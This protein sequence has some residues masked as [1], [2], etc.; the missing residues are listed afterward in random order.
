L[1]PYFVLALTAPIAAALILAPLPAY[2]QAA[3]STCS[4][5]APGTKNCDDV[6]TGGIGYT[7]GVD[8]VN[9]SNTPAGDPS[10]VNVNSGTVG[11]LLT[12]I[13]GDGSSAV[14]DAALTT[15]VH[16]NNTPGDTNDDF[17]ALTNAGGSF[18]LDDNGN[19]IHVVDVDVG[20]GVT[21]QQL[22]DAGGN[23]L[24]LEDLDTYL[25]TLSS[26]GAGVPVGAVTVV[27]SANFQS[28]NA[29]G[30][31]ATA[32]GGNGGKGGTV[33]IL[34]IGEVG[35]KG[36][37]GRSGGSVAVTND[38]TITATG[39][40]A[41]GIVAT[42]RGGNGGEG[43]GLG[44]LVSKAGSGGN[45]GAGGDVAVE[46]QAGSDITTTGDGGHGVL[47][48]SF[49]GDGGKG[50]STGG[51]VALGSKGGNGGVGGNVTVDNAGSI[52]TSGEAA[53]GIYARSYGAGAGSGSSVGGIYAA[54]G[55]GGGDNADGGTVDVSNSGTITT[56]GIGS[57]GVYLQSI[58]GGGGD[59]GNAG[60]L[61]TVGGK[62]GSGGDG[63]AVTYTQTDTGSVTTTKDNATAILA[64]S[65]GGGG[66]N[67]G[68]A[69]SISPVAV[70]IGGDAGPGGDG[71]TVTLNVAGTVTTSGKDANGIQA[72]SIGGGGGTGGLAVAGSI[73]PGPA[74][75][76]ALGG[77]GGDGGDAKAVEVISTAAITTGDDR[78]NGIFAQSVGGGG[79][80]G[81]LAISAAVG[82]G[83]FSAA[84]ALGGSG[85]PGGS[86]GKVTVDQTGAIVTGGD[87][88]VGINAQSIGGGGGN[89]GGSVAVAASGAYSLGFSMGG[90]AG[91]GGTAGAVDV[92]LNGSIAT[93]GNLSHG[94]FA[95]S[96]GGGGGNGGYSVAATAG[97]MSGSLALGGE[98]AGGATGGTVNVT[99]S[100]GDGDAITTQGE[101]AVGIFAQSVGGGGGNGGIAGS[102]ALGGGGIGVSLGGSGGGGSVGGTVDVHNEISIGTEGDKA[103]GILAQSVGGGGG[104][105]GFALSGAGGVVGIGAAIGGS[106]GA[107]S[108]G[109]TVDVYSSGDI[110]TLGK[111]AYGIQAQSVGGG[112]GNGGFAVSGAL[113]VSVQGIPGASAAIAI[114][115]TGGEA[116]NGDSVDVTNEGS[117]ETSGEGSHAIFAQSVG[118]G[119]GAG[120]FAGSLAATV[121]NG[122]AF[123]LSLGGDGGGGGDGGAVE[124]T[125]TGDMIIT[126]EAGA[127]GIHAQ[128]IGG[129]GGDGGFAFSGAI[130]LGESSSL[131]LSFG[132]DGEAGG[133]GSTVQ[134]TNES[135][136]TTSGDQAHGILAQSVGGGGGSGA[137]SVGGSAS[138]KGN[139]IALSFGGDGG[140]GGKGDHVTVS[141]LGDITT[142]GDGSYGILAQSIGGGGGAGGFSGALSLSGQ[143]DAAIAASFGGSAAN[144]STAGDVSVTHKLGTISTSGDNATGVFAQSVGGSGGT[145]GFSLSAAGS[146]D[147]T[148]QSLSVGGKGGE[149]QDSGIVVVGGTVDRATGDVTQDS[150]TGTIV[151]TGAMS[152]GIQAQSIGGGGGNGGFSVGLSFSMKDDAKANS[153][154]GEGEGGGDANRVEVYNE[155]TIVTGGLSGEG[156]GSHGIFAQSVGGGGGSGGFSA[157]GA[158][159]MEGE[160]A[161]SSVGGKG[162]RAGDGE[163]VI[164]GSA[165]TIIT[166]AVNSHG[167]L[168]QSIGGGGG[169]GAFSLAAGATAGDDA[170]SESVGGSGGSGGTGGDVV[171]DVLADI[172]TLGDLSY[173]VLAQSVGGGGGSGGFSISGSASLE[174]ESSNKSVGGS[175]SGGGDG[176]NVTV[177]IGAEGPPLTAP[178][179][180]TY[181][182]GAIGVLAQSIGG[183]G[184]NGGFSGGLSLATS[185][186]AENSV[187]SKKGANGGLAGNG[188]EVSV[189]NWGNVLTEGNNAAGIL[190]QSVGGGGGNGGFTI[191][192]SLDSKGGANNSIGGAAAG[193]GDGGLVEVD[194]N[195]TIVTSGNF[196]HGIIAQSIGG[197]GGNGGFSVSGSMS[198]GDNGA[199]SKIGGGAGGGGGDGGDVVVNNSG[200]ILVE[201]ENSFGVFA[202]SVGG[203]GGAGGFAGGLALGGK[204][205]NS[206][207]GE[208]G[209]GGDGGDVTV[210]ST[211]SIVTTQANSSA[212][213][214]QS[215]AGGGGWGGFSIALGTS[216]TAST[217]LKQGLGALSTLYAGTTN[218]TRGTVTVNISGGDTQT[219]GSLSYGLLAQSVGGGGGAVGTVAAGTFAIA[220]GDIEI[221]VGS[222]GSVDGD[223]LKQESNYANNTTTDGLGAIGLISQSIGGGGG[224]SGTVIEDTLALSGTETFDVQV[225][226]YSGGAGL[227]GSGSGGGFELNAQGT[228]ETTNDNAIGVLAQTIGGGGGVGNITVNE[229]TG[230]AA[231]FALTLGGSQTPDTPNGDGGPA[232]SV[233]ADENI[234]THGLLSHGLVAQSI[235]GGG[236]VANTVFQ[237]AATITAGATVTLGS[238]DAKASGDGG[239]VTA[240]TNG[241]VETNGAGA[242]GIVAQSIGGGGGLAGFANGGNVFG[243][244]GFTFNQAGGDPVTIVAGAAPDGN[245]G[246]VF[247]N[248]DGNVRTTGFGAHGIVAQSV[249]GGGGIVGAG[250][251]SSTLGSEPFAGSVG[252]S[253]SAGTVS[254]ATTKNVIANNE[255]SFGI[256][257]QSASASTA[258]N[259]AVSV[260][261][262]NAGNGVGLVW[263]GYGNGA[264]VRIDGGTA[265][266]TLN[267]D[268]TLYATGNTPSPS[269]LPLINGLAIS[270][271]DGGE[272]ATN[273]AYTFAP[274]PAA[275][276][277]DYGS[278]YG[279]VFDIAYG[280]AFG[281]TRTSNII[282]NVD[283]G[284]GENSLTLEEGSLF[285]SEAF[286]K[287]DDDD[288]PSAGQTLT[289]NGLL[290]PGDRGRVQVTS[291]AGNYAQSATGKY[292]IDVDLDS[293]TTDK[294][295]LTGS[296]EVAGEGPLLLTSINKKFN[297][298]VIIDAPSVGGTVTDNGFTPT[299]EPSAVGFDF[300]VRVDPSGDGQALVLYADKPAFGTD[301]L[302][303][304]ASGTTDPNVFRMGT[305]LDNI[306][307]AIDT[308]DPFNY[309]I[310]LLRLSPDHE[311]LGDAVVSL[312]PSNAPHIYEVTR[313]R[314]SDFLDAAADCPYDGQPGSVGDSRNCIWA[315]ASYGEYERDSVK[316]SPL[317]DDEWYAFTLG[318]QVALDMNWQLGFG[319]ESTSVDSAQTRNGARLSDLSA[320]I[321]QFS[322]SATYQDGPFKA[323]LVSAGSRGNWDSRRWV[324]I[325]GFAQQFSS[326][327]GIDTATD[328]PIFSN[329]ATDFEAI[330]GI[331]ASDTELSGFSQL[332]RLSYLQTAGAFEVI[333][334]FDV[335]GHVLHTSARTESG[336]GLAN[337]TYRSQTET[338]VTFTPGIELG[339]T[340]KIAPQI[341]MR[342]FVRTGVELAPDNI[343]TAQTQFVAAPAG[344][345]NAKIKESFDEATFKVD[346]GLMLLDANGLELNVNYS[347]AF[348]ET[349]A[350]N[351][352]RGNVTVKY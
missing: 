105:G 58:G 212:V 45:G 65:I 329:K 346:A 62:A 237:D 183:G 184:G 340:G 106:G 17:D 115:G 302:Q 158:F 151:T 267:S 208:G 73:S 39:T 61:F 154:G 24:P 101:G 83:P 257:A 139:S 318:G 131:A 316:D 117:I 251:F 248:A 26:G 335:E 88:S 155:A 133:D 178:T 203:G 341:S 19:P 52:S 258:T 67:G 272:T 314:S 252:G 306:E 229:V 44:A 134:V 13:G 204:V 325:N 69:V 37:N 283:L 82:S 95:Q 188:G 152:H 167:I 27:N 66:G 209:A 174:S 74:I 119:G 92:D 36:G 207:G 32:T 190:A 138:L 224:V 202:Q 175:G 48:Q 260:D 255:D 149:G 107:G 277:F 219:T 170:E 282:G 193:G 231:S 141:N 80:D 268:G 22:Q 63:K 339:L 120:G 274:L 247:V 128:S 216:G 232:S 273:L 263:G 289:N 77:S 317:S 136:I 16:D 310:N 334:Y 85:G 294:L 347:G 114:G 213:F 23:P 301:L 331:A 276:T 222:N 189:T 124:V 295:D 180:H 186:S 87:N 321:Y 328:T 173:G 228:V 253:G 163:Q 211:G 220:A 29:D 89:G 159:S 270:G 160:A 250:N 102:I 84:V 40:D 239:E 265:A 122:A 57:Y 256:F 350:E 246:S 127:D 330:N 191:T 30:I 43:G 112:G 56:D 145:G 47:A 323:T 144:G 299:L 35:K 176:G 5:G 98:G 110:T 201:G 91:V 181:G 322:V 132:G 293:Q 281:G 161:A 297:E 344:L 349:S 125:S 194:N 81:G 264:A 221:Q 304:P 143:G 200:Q 238:G 320:D 286:A 240:T 345:E 218:G 226:G 284:A 210:T 197:G 352:V 217:G 327:D 148:A 233:T 150:V 182:E 245:G 129:G 71:G 113:G 123:G 103:T 6:P 109:G 254:V 147:G 54:G 319:F 156:A 59:G 165:G 137:F 311:T 241:D 42:S 337:L 70:A 2:A 296:A 111:L 243:Q 10:Q 298:Y 18:V 351:E 94:I 259:G 121:G 338:T 108:D 261:V 60:G 326:F 12:D 279:I 164:V 249:G 169:S 8:Q 192:A 278:D 93:T 206:V 162:D 336:V 288:T 97:S 177:T 313:R 215:V 244:S 223:G 90:A 266:N 235:G 20:N 348:G 275:N 262:S 68:N 72:Q 309:L 303:D 104:N 172:S 53:Y 234:T 79:G 96:V 46:L 31:V 130:A 271:G 287:L 171:V 242:F 332:L 118:G 64:Q 305:N 140:R 14:N 205:S 300:N 230:S 166:T 75:S 100:G 195:G 185:G 292:F 86:A 269:G 153:I 1:R 55:N 168:A 291:V 38:G 196:S 3:N 25:S 285:I 198:T 179:I 307:A 308:D 227:I 116:S 199:K 4:D 135:I 78:S 9:V 99:T 50:G 315:Q 51:A 21:E 7:S 157:A 236:G 324:N 142:Q 343:W 15:A 76:V 126:H 49:G 333:P 11:I 34:F 290:S 312:T 28:T 187:G 225:G 146:L 342:G 33:N 214:A 280:A 41:R